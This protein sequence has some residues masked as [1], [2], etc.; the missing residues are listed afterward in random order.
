MRGVQRVFSSFCW[1]NGL[2]GGTKYRIREANDMIQGT[3]NS[4]DKK[5]KGARTCDVAPCQD[6]ISFN[7]LTL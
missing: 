4:T 1:D 7:D 6:T 3:I 2:L 5:Y